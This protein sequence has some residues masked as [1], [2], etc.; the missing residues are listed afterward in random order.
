MVTPAGRQ[1][2]PVSPAQSS[3]GI[4]EPD[5]G[6]YVLPFGQSLIITVGANPKCE[7]PY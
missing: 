7:E 2:V 5:Y 4:S 3:G 6:G 1:T